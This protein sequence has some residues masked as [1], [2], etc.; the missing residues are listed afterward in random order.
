MASLC[1]SSRSL[2]GL[3][4]TFINLAYGRPGWREVDGEGGAGRGGEAGHWAAKVAT[5]SDNNKNRRKP[6]SVGQVVDDGVRFSMMATKARW[7]R[8]AGAG[9]PSEYLH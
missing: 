2:T 7:Q 1:H 6:L 5:P 9:F 4:G 3:R 8:K